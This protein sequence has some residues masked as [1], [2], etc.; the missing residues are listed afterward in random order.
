MMALLD[1]REVPRNRALKG[2]KIVFNDGSSVLSCVVRDLSEKGA[3]L[4]IDTV[5]GVP[6]RFSL[7]IMNGDIRPCHLIWQANRELGVVFD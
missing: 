4:K 1:R 5:I 2:A 3:R 6:D 7:Q